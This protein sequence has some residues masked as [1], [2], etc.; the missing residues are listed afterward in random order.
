MAPREAEEG[1]GGNGGG[2]L[3]QRDKWKEG[4]GAWSRPVGGAALSERGSTGPLTRGPRST[5][6]GRGRGEAQ[7][8]WPILGKRGVGRAHMN[9]IFFIYSIKSQT[10]LNC[11]D[12]KVDLPRSKKSK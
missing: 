8:A 10:S 7:G 9:K 5:A 6:E 3:A 4:E 11:F 2:S 12:Q 1:G